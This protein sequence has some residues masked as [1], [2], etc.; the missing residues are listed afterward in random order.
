[1]TTCPRPTRLVLA[2]TT[3]LFA[4]SAVSVPEKSHAIGG[5]LL[6]PIEGDQ[7]PAALRESTDAAVRRARYVTVDLSVMRAPGARQM[8]REP[9]IPL[10][11]F[12]DVTLFAVFERYDR[13]PGGMTWVGRVEGVPRSTVTLSYG[14]GLL[15]GTVAMSN[16]TYHIRPAAGGGANTPATP[17]HVVTQVDQAAF[18]PEA[19]PIQVR[20]TAEQL[21]AAADTPM[22]DTADQI[23]L[24]V[25]YTDLAAAS[26]GGAQGILNLINLGV[27]ETNTSYA[28]SGVTHRIRLVH[29][30]QVPYVESNNFSTNLND[31]RF[32]VGGL[33]GVAALRDAY[34]ADMVTM[35][36]D[37]PQ[38]SACGIAT[39][40]TQVSAAFAASAFSVTDTS[41]VSPNFTFAHELG[42]NMGARHD[43]FVDNGTTPFTY[44]HGYVNAA[45][46]Q[47][48]RTI[49]AYPN[50]CTALGFSC[51]RVLYWAN[52]DNRFATACDSRRFNCGQLQFWYYPGVPMGV[53]AGTGIGC[54]TGNT[55]ST[56]CDAD[57][58]RTLNNTALT[59]ANF[60]QRVVADR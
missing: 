35:L 1:M 60:R 9:A 11:L 15:T 36:V 33:S 45:A 21:A 19:E 40:M 58:R 22:S 14:G 28:N 51:T 49:M 43:W 31:L 18:P 5:A 25:V 54:T 13:S 24:L 37:P 59:V 27:S 12:P 17:L 34:G 57:D 44:A 4:A 32:G 10:E 42:H 52:P 46:G 6:V 26:A 29:A 7:V 23:D 53:P 50:M 2:L 8:L 48:W 20:L 16:A 30:A 56:N 55:S 38:P 47:R 3:C 41:C 39:L